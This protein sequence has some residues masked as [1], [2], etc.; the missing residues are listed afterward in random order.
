MVSKVA[1]RVL[2]A[3]LLQVM[4]A[5]GAMAQARDTNPLEP[6]NVLDEIV[7]QPGAV[8]DVG[9]PESW[10]DFKDDIYDRYGLRFGF[11]YQILG[12]NASDTLPGATFDTAVGRLVGIPSRRYARPWGRNSQ[13]NR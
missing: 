10:F 8:F 1:L 4:V 5:G 13:W 12:Q 7:P 11:S 2:V 3:C 9:I 6:G